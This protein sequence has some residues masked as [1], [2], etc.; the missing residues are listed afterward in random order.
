MKVLV[1]IT[2]IALFVSIISCKHKKDEMPCLDCHDPKVKSAITNKY[3]LAA[4]NSHEEPQLFLYD[5]LTSQ[6]STGFDFCTFSSSDEFKAMEIINASGNFVQGCNKVDSLVQVTSFKIIDA[7]PTP[8]PDILLQFSLMDHH[9]YVD[10]LQFNGLVYLPPCGYHPEIL[11]NDDGR[12]FLALVINGT[13][14][15]YSLIGNDSI[16]LEPGPFTL[17]IA[18]TFYERDYEQTLSAIIGWIPTSLEMNT[19]QYELMN[20]HLILTSKKGRIV[21][22]CKT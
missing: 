9:W 1:G 4:Y 14:A 5:T 2:Q 19:L 10:S 15:H 8:I 17:A 21:L 12:Y 20:N 6:A 18:R 3:F 22:H 11:F 7:C 13:V 16:K